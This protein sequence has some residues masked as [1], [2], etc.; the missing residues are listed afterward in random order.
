[1]PQD[2]KATKLPPLRRHQKEKLQL[3]ANKY[4]K[5]NYLTVIFTDEDRPLF[6]GSGSSAC[7]W[8]FHG[9]SKVERLR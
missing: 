9:N 8:G 4:K 6:E 5:T 3:L 1:M 2:M 7:G